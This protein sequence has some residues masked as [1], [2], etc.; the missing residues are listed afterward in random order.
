MMKQ[1]KKIIIITTLI[2]LLPIFIG[3]ILWNQLP[4]QIAIHFDF[5]GTPD[6]F[7]NKFLAITLVPLFMTL[8]HLFSIFVTL[9]DPKKQNIGNKMLNIIF[10]IIPFFANITQ[11]SIIYYTLNTKFNVCFIPFL[12]IGFLFIILGNYMSKTHQNYTVG[13]KIPWTL[14]S[15][16]NWNK[17]HRFAS[18][19]WMLSGVILLI[20]CF[21]NIPWILFVVILITVIFP[22]IY[23]FILYKKGI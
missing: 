13:I 20:N 7:V 18:K 21:L 5:S 12:S 3:L 14:N 17:T 8:V 23:S 6:Q 4:N 2:T 22:M 9:H 11:L 19:L 10:W 16:E 1:Y 15:R